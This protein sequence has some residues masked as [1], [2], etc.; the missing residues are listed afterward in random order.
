MKVYITRDK[1][2]FSQ[3]MAQMILKHMYSG[4]PR[5]NLSITAGITPV[6]GYQILAEQVRDRDYFDNVHYYVFDDIFIRGEKKE[7]YRAASRTGEPQLYPVKNSASGIVREN[8][9]WKYFD[10]A[11]VKPDHI[12]DITEENY[13]EVDRMIAQ[14]GGLDMIIMGLGPDGHICGNLPGTVPYWNQGARMVRADTTPGTMKMVRG[15]LDEYN[16]TDESRLPEAYV[17]FGPKT[18][19]DARHAI[20]IAT[21]E[22]KAEIV[23]RVLCEP[24]SLDVPASVLQL[25]RDLTVLLDREAAAL[26]MDKIGN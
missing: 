21:G 4:K 6:R 12:H 23:R 25:H 10:P 5:V 13:M 22:E 24:V 17:S 11:G 19:L 20:L 2:D 9:D 16:L 14:A 18:V 7:I 8:L 1:E 26:M 15:C 3:V